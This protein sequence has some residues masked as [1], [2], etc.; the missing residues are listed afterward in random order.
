MKITTTHPEEGNEY[1]GTLT[2]ELE[3]NRGNN[4]VSF[5]AGEPEDFSLG[6]DLNDAYKIEGMLIMAYK[7]GQ[8]GEKL[9]I[10]KQ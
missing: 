1:D 4:R 8:D 3:T 7:A 10:I 9:D 2:V 5:G 6:R